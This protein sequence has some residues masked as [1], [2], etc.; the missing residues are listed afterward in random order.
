MFKGTGDNMAE[1]FKLRLE[2]E[3][4]DFQLYLQGLISMGQDL[5]TAF[6]GTGDNMAEGFKLRL[7]KE[8]ADFQ[9]YLQGLISQ[10]RELTEAF[11]GTGDNMVEGFKIRQEKEKADFQ[12][13]L[14]GLIS[15][16][17]ELTE[18]FRGTGDGMVKVFE[19]R[20]AQVHA[21]QDELID[22]SRAWV[23][24]YQELGGDTQSFYAHKMDLVRAQLAKELDLNKEQAA[25]LLVA[26]REH[27]R[28]RAEQI[29]AG[30]PVSDVR[31]KTV[32]LNTMRDIGNMQ[33]ANGFFDG[34]AKGMRNYV[35]DTQSGFGLAAD[36][37]RRTA[38]MMEQ[39][40]QTFFFDAMEGKINSLKDVLKSLL[41]FAKNLIAQVGAQLVTRQIVGA[42]AGA[43]GASPPKFAM[44]GMGDFGA[45]SMAILHG[46]EAVVPLPDGRSIPVMLQ[47]MGGQSPSVTVPI[48]IEV[49]NQ[50]QGA[51]VETQR[52]TGADGKQQIRLIVRQEMK[53][54]FGDGSMDGSMQRYGAN[55]KPIGR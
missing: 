43:G 8:K 34:W 47:S 41:D 13:Y 38:Q 31:K 35:R 2:K 18:A 44:G 54:A 17:Q 55:T 40:F 37:A 12:L 33:E 51:K 14:Q 10:G 36:M 9:L 50:V 24:Y 1:G 39:G 28:A 21:E 49:I 26:W 23:Q 3:K 45:G 20:R 11:S 15:M 29:T 4:D 22:N 32:Q 7:E 52:S 16:G 19:D 5:T 46:R 48:H 30:S 25:E 42:F 27:D 53:S 6:S